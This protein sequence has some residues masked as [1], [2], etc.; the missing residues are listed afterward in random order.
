MGSSPAITVT[1]RNVNTGIVMVPLPSLT[2]APN[3]ITS[4]KASNGV[5]SMTLSNLVKLLLIASLAY[6]SSGARLSLLLPLAQAPLHLTL[7]VTISEVAPLVV[8]LL[9]AG[10][11]ELELGPAALEIKFCRDQG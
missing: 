8:E 5:P 11:A 7:G 9:A 1:A 10:D 2:A 3:N 6:I 4:P